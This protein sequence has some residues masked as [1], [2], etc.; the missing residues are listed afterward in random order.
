MT[1][2]VELT[3]ALEA[4]LRD[5]AARRGFQVDEYAR[6]ILEVQLAAHPGEPPPRPFHETATAEEWKSGFHAWVES[7]RGINL[8]P[9]TD[10]SLRR[11][12][13]YEDRW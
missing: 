2:T 3:P 9:L 11:D 12:H 8:P 13:L 4:R 6:M 7:H 5:E 1:V 10:E